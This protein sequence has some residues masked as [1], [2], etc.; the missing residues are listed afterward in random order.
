MI[1]NTFNWSIEFHSLLKYKC[2]GVFVERLKN[3]LNISHT[4]WAPQ[5]PESFTLCKIHK[6]KNTLWQTN[7]NHNFCT[8]I[9]YFIPQVTN[10]KR[11]AFS[12]CSPKRIIVVLDSLWEESM[13]THSFLVKRASSTTRWPAGMQTVWSMSWVWVLTST[14]QLPEVT[15]LLLLLFYTGLYKIYQQLFYKWHK[16]K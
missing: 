14:A 10:M 16:E 4:C 5:P 8:S 11:R 1:H 13:Y 2:N 9:F 3:K 6:N 12:L 15:H 7:S